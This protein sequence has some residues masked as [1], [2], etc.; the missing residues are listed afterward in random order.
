MKYFASLLFL[1]LCNVTL[2]AQSVLEYTLEK[3]TTFTIKQD[4]QQ[5][6][7]QELDGATHELINKIDGILEFK[8]LAK[9]DSTYVIA[10]IF[11][12]LNL[13]MTSSIQGEL[14]NVHTKEI[15]EDDMQSKIFSSLLNSP[16]QMVLAKTGDIL[17]VNG[18]DSLVIK[19]AEASG[20]KDDFSLNMMKKS[21]QKE[22]GSEALSD[23]Y[24]QMTFIYPEKPIKIG[25]N[26]KNKYLGKLGAKNT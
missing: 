9:R 23:S 14:M 12:D 25:D 1:L 7:T 20:L 26:W 10:L 17:E 15:S 2:S 4:A 22:F 13:K 16:V 24:K 6:I 21:L 3:G 11:K 8:V 19:M 5:V 18:G